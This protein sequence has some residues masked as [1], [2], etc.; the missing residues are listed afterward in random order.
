VQKFRSAEVQELQNLRAASFERQDRSQG[1]LNLSCAAAWH[2]FLNSCNSCTPALLHS[3]PY[4][5]L[6]ISRKK[7]A[8]EKRL[9]SWP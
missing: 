2:S 6:K 4:S 5:P 1:Y 7:W 3:S 8:S 9:S